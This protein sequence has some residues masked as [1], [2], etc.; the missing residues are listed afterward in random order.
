[1]TARLSFDELYASLV[2]RDRARLPG[3]GEEKLATIRRYAELFFGGRIKIPSIIVS[4]T[5]G[6]GSTCEVASTILSQNGLKTGLFTSPHLASAVERIRINGIPITETQYVDAYYRCEA[7][8]K[9]RETI[10]PGYFALHVMMAGLIFLESN[11]DVLVIECGLG[12]RYDWTQIFEPTVTGITSLGYDHLGILG[13][14]PESISNHKFGICTPQSINF[15][16]TQ[17]PEFDVALTAL[18]DAAGI[19]ITT[20]PPVYTG[21]MGLRGP[22]AAR[23]S[24]LGAA[25]AIAIGQTVT[26]R[27]LP[28]EAGIASTTINGRY[29][30]LPREGIDW[31]VDGAH[32]VE[33][34]EGCWEWYCSLNRNPLLDVL[35]CAT[36]HARDPTVL[37]ERVLQGGNWKQVIWV[38][39]YLERGGIPGA[40]IAKDLNEA[41]AIAKGANPKGVFVTGSLHLVGDVM[42]M[43]G[44][45]LGEPP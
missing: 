30:I 13:K 23:N 24:A 44:W 12:G 6:K 28:V 40:T 2:A 37:L 16:T 38:Q 35:M 5:K 27:S 14:T 26:G 4:G 8:C 29:H 31:I 3:R 18:A 34:I 7:V 43:L 36:T 32:T 41:I 17:S 15:T 9:E 22:T 1:M 11:L 21:A 20:V 19:K 45:R 25:L 10:L 42:R 33:S 39:S